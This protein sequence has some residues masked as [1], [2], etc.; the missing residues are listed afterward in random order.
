MTNLNVNL[1]NNNP[2]EQIRLKM[3]FGSFSPIMTD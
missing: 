1:D 2:Y 3:G